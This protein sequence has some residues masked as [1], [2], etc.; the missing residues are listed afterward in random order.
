VVQ[1]QHEH[2]VAGSQPEQPGAPGRRGDQ[3]ETLGCG[4]PDGIAQGGLGDLGHRQR[5]R[6]RCE[7]LL[8]GPAIAGG[9]GG[10]EYLMPFG[11]VG[12][13]GGQGG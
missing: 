4:R 11:D 12:Q 5:H 9:E 10:P 8:V 13:R 7:D 1:D 3:V 2:V 6:P